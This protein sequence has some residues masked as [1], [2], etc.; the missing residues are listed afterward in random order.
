MIDV[1]LVDD[2][3]FIREG[4]N[5]VLS[6]AEEIR[7]VGECGD[8]EEV[9]EKLGEK[10]KVDIV[11][12]D[13]NMPRVGGF[14]ATQS[15]LKEFPR[16]KVVALT[17]HESSIY[18]ERFREIGGVGYILKNIGKHEFVDAIRRIHSGEK[19]F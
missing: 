2:H 14:E 16:L 4:I 6:S 5:G 8:G 9:L 3:K 7:V 12:M 10:E 15:I 13:L 11:L 18:A 19:Y 17:M 1:L